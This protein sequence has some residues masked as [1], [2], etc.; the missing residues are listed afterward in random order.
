MKNI[1][2]FFCGLFWVIGVFSQSSDLS[3]DKTV[4]NQFVNAGD[5]VTFTIEVSN[6]GPGPATG[7]RVMDRLPSGYEFVSARTTAG[8]YE[9]S[10]GIW[11]IGRLGNGIS[12]A[13]T[14]IAKVQV[15]GNHLNTAEIIASNMLDADS[16][17]NNGVDTDKD[18]NVMDD[19]QDE[20]DGDGQLV[21]VAG[22]DSFSKKPG[23][24]SGECLAPLD[25]ESSFPPNPENEINGIFKFDYKIEALVNFSGANIDPDYARGDPNQLIMEYYVNSADGSIMFPGGPTGF[26]KTNMSYPNS[27]GTIDAAIWLANGQMVSYVYDSEEKK[28]RAITRKVRRPQTDALAMTT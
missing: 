2:F 4:N 26:F 23:M 7:V 14:L 8:N 5:T 19:P 11:N 25:A 1:S 17:P 13:L 27:D 10:S 15:S 24:A 6:N 20:D 12:V 28:W 21:I 18:G 3:L 16:V 22:S 9:Q